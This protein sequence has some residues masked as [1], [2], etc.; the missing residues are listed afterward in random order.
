MNWST[1]RYAWAGNQYYSIPGFAD[2]GLEGEFAVNRQWG[3][4]FKV[5]NLLNQTVQLY[6]LHAENGIYFTL[7]FRLTI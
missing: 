7:G 4:W 5:G 6:P 3:V 1:A 2:L